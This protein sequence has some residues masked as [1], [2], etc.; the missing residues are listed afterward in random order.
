MTRNPALKGDL[1]RDV[2]SCLYIT[3]LITNVHGE[4]LQYIHTHIQ[5][6]ILRDVT[7]YEDVIQ[8]EQIN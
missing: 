6:F 4:I 5:Y 3:S 8:N 1:R 7:G 2:M